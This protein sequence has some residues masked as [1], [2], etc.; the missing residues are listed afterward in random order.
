MKRFVFI[1]SIFAIITPA[2]TIASAFAGDMRECVQLTSEQA[3][4]QKK[5]RQVLV[6]NCSTRV[7][8]F[9][10]H[11]GG[12][13]YPC[14]EPKHYRQGRYFSPGERHFNSYTLPDRVSINYGACSGM[15]TRIEY[16]ANGSYRCPSETDIEGKGPQHGQAQCDD[17]RKVNFEWQLK[18][19]TE[20]FS[21]VKLKDGAVQI[22]RAEYRAFEKKPDGQPPKAL[23]SRLCKSAPAGGGSDS[24]GTLLN[25]MKSWT[26]QKADELEKKERDACARKGNA[27]EDCRRFREPPRPTPQA[28]GKL[29]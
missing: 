11:V 4:G 22:P 10:C 5:S 7:Y 21:V 12:G 23:V 1:I 8:V 6:N 18:G 19:E 29:G 17:G 2:F 16:G 20:K 25:D 3:P 13:A 9:W 15:Y 24:R 14:K 28:G 27:G 26:R